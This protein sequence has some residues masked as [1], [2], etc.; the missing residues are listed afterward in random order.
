MAVDITVNFQKKVSVKKKPEEVFDYISDF[1]RT[2]KQI[3]DLE[4]FAKKGKNRYLWKFKPVGAMG[5]EI[6]AKYETDV[7]IIEGKGVKWESIPGSGN[8][9]VR[10]EFK[11]KKKGKGSELELIVETTAHLPIPR[12]A[13]RIA[14]PYV[15]DNVKKVMEGYLANLKN[16][17]EK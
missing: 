1:E 8:T 5:V 17:L 13:K 3:P 4:K 11:I 16:A 7:E 10:G 15:E 12:L 6:A 14:K 9:D 2:A